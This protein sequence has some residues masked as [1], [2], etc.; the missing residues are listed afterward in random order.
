MVSF[1]RRSDPPVL[2]GGPVRNEKPD[3]MANTAYTG[4]G[5]ALGHIPEAGESRIHLEVEGGISNAQ[6]RELTLKD[7]QSPIVKEGTKVFSQEIT[8]GEVPEFLMGNE[9]G[10]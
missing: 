5:Q 10:R 6:M 9:P 2:T 4:A 1:R 3:W 8:G 7:P